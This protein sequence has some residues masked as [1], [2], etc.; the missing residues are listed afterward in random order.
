MRSAILGALILAPPAVWAQSKPAPW[1][2]GMV[3]PV[4]GPFSDKVVP[5]GKTLAQVLD[6]FQPDMAEWSRLP[7]LKDHPL[8]PRAVR[9]GTEYQESDRG[10]I[11]LWKEL[12][13]E[14]YTAGEDNGTAVLLNGK[15]SRHLAWG[16]EREG[17]QRWHVCHNSPR[18]H[19]LHKKTILDA[20]RDPTVALIRQDNLGG[21]AGI[22]TPGGWCKYCQAGF[23][24]YLARKYDAP[25][26]RKLALEDLKQFR[27]RE[28]FLGL[29]IAGNAQAVLRSRLARE[30]I[31]FLQL[32]NLAAWQD[33]T[34]AARAIRPDI[35][36]CGN[37]GSGGCAAYHFF[38]ITEPN[39]LSF[40]ER[41]A[42]GF[43]DRPNIFE[44]K[45][46]CAAGRH[47][48]PT[49]IW[50]FSSQEMMED[51]TGSE[52]F[53]AECYA[54]QVVP[55]YL[56]NN[57]RWTAQKG[58]ETVTLGADAYEALRKLAAF[59]REHRDLIAGTY[60]AYADTAL[61]YSLPSFRF[62][63]SSAFN[64]W[65]GN[66][67]FRRQEGFLRGWANALEQWHQPYDVIVFGGPPELW[68][69]RDLAAELARYR[70]VVLSNVTALT[71]QQAAAVRRYVAD[72]GAVVVAGELGRYD[73]MY[74][75][76]AEPLLPEFQ[77]PGDREIGKGRLARIGEEPLEFAGA[78]ASATA[79]GAL[80]KLRLD[81]REPQNLVVSG[82]SKAEK[83]RGSY[84]Q[85]SIWCDCTY[86]DGGH[87]WAQIAPFKHGTRDWHR[88]ELLIKPA[89][90]LK[91]VAVICLFRYHTGRAWFDDLSVTVEGSDK[92]LLQ[93]PGFEASGGWEKFGDGFELDRTVK[94]TGKQSIRCGKIEGPPP[95]PAPELLKMSAAW[96]YARG[97]TA[98]LVATDA[99]LTAQINPVLKG[100]R[101]IVHAVNFNASE[102][103]TKQISVTVGLPEGKTKAEQGRLLTPGQEDRPLAATV[104]QGRV[105][106]VLPPVRVWTMAVFQLR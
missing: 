58:V 8:C 28:Y 52:I 70:V 105:S 76:R 36:I 11:K 73:E 65:T 102:A 44:Y 62:K 106:F 54:N 75:P 29:K 31:H 90:P 49:L 12:Y 98:P 35:P 55:Y 3:V 100:D 84:G 33:T 64:L 24:Q 95:P 10:G 50:G 97:D 53:I 69:D 27:P 67:E 2:Y 79:Y 6:D 25:T 71:E 51:V 16:G 74:E 57:L 4:V 83:A 26:L 88:S 14:D 78:A 92:N 93:A 59:A 77:A 66:P 46:Q 104:E 34:A 99:P 96:R 30:Y 87:L 94:H 56:M 20:V 81:Q 13:G 91:D 48:K 40:L 82:W 41:S 17:A 86:Q 43:P 9:G 103:P 37:Q 7:T 1:I 68:P 80:Q 45:L 19:N 21:P 22:G 89:K 63:T 5:A 60:R 32:S 18:W 23:K 42:R 38:I 101:L 39:D 61:V 15:F 47:R 72:G 85:Y